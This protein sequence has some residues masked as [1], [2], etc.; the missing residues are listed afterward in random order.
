MHLLS[1]HNIKENKPLK[2]QSHLKDTRKILQ[3]AKTKVEK[4]KK[5]TE[6]QKGR[7]EEKKK[8]RG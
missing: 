5:E 4:R 2:I 7:R 8:S 3:L 6:R 1:S